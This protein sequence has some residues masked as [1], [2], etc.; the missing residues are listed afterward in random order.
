MSYD[1]KAITDQTVKD[2]STAWGSQLDEMGDETSF[3]ASGVERIVDW[4]AKAI[5]QDKNHLWELRT[6]ETG[7]IRAVVEMTDARN[8][9][10]P[11]FKFLNIYLEPRL[12]L[13]F[14]EEI[15]K[16]DIEEV[17]DIF[18]Y[19]MMASFDVAKDNGTTK[20]KIYGRTNEMVSLFDSLVL[21]TGTDELDFTLYRQSNWLVI[22]RR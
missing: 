21:N 8:S 9:K 7:M 19:A 3:L 6:K 11:S 5:E 2:I 10:D 20:L 4:C 1:L 17:I 15:R 12:I 22:E 16:E 13:D 18:A 14:K